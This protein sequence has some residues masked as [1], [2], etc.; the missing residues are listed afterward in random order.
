MSSRLLEHG[1]HLPIEPKISGTQNLSSEGVMAPF[2]VL[3]AVVQ[4]L[5]PAKTNSDRFTRLSAIHMR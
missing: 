3:V 1:L 2:G 4:G 5:V